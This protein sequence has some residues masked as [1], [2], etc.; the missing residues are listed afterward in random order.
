MPYT[1][2]I[3]S[4]QMSYT[5]QSDTSWACSRSHWGASLPS[6]TLQENWG[7][8]RWQPCP[9]KGGVCCSFE[10]T[11]RSGIKLGFSPPQQHGGKMVPCIWWWCSLL[12]QQANTC[13]TQPQTKDVGSEPWKLTDRVRGSQEW[14]HGL[15]STFRP[16]Q[17]QAGDSQ[18]RRMSM[19]PRLGLGDCGMQLTG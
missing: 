12:T 6:L 5:T 14:P 17:D 16:V 1:S 4:L 11:T 3:V 8:S 7:A 19:E 2:H 15:H 9:L 10:M 13:R 18:G